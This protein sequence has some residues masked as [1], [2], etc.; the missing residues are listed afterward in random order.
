MVALINSGYSEDE[1]QRKAELI[2]NHGED[3]V[4]DTEEL[5]RDF[6]VEG[7]MAPF[8]IVRRR[9]DNKQGTVMF[10]HSPRFYF[11]FKED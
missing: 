1:A 9:S 6:V 5:S 2:E 10:T 3:N 8:T 4:W 11:N 7:F